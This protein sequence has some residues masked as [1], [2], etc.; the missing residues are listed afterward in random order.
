MNRRKL[1]AWKYPRNWKKVSL[2]IRR[3]A[4]GHCE[5][6][7]AEC[8]NL[9]VHHIGVPWA[10]GRPNSPSNKHDLRRENLV[11]LCWPCHQEADRPAHERWLARKA[12]RYTKREVH[13]SL[14]IGTGLIP[15]A[16]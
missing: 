3:L 5:W 9:S 4:N 15:I 11:A 13:R 6:C 2:L 8:S 16:A 7:G 10:D 12:A 1:A 14:G